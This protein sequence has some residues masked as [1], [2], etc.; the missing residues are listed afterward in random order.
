MSLRGAPRAARQRLIARK[1][2]GD[3]PG[4]PGG[5][6]LSSQGLEGDRTRTLTLTLT[7]NRVDRGVLGYLVGLGLD[8]KGLTLVG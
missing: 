4:P 5:V 3:P 6:R 2:K 1:P 7:G 8:G